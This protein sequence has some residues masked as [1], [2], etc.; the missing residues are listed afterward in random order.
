MI[1]PSLRKLLAA[2]ARSLDERRAARAEASREAPSAER[3]SEILDF[4]ARV[5]AGGDED[6]LGR[7]LGWDG[8]TPEEAVEAAAWEEAA[9]APWTEFLWEALSRPRGER[10][11]KEPPEFGAFRVVPAFATAWIPFV[12]AARERA[13]RAESVDAELFAPAA[14]RALE[15]GLLGELARL[16]QGVFPERLG[17]RS[18][19]DAQDASPSERLEEIFLSFPVLARLV[20][21]LATDWV[22]STCELRSRLR[23]DRAA[24][25]EAFGAAGEVTAVRSA[26]SDRHRGGRRVAILTFRSGARVVYK[27]RAVGLEAEWN[28]FLEWLRASGARDAPPALRFVAREGY[29]WSEFAA[30]APLADE[31]AVAAYF[32]RAGGLLAVAWLLGARDFHMDN[33]V[34]TGAGPVVVDAEAVLQ[35][36]AAP[37]SGRGPRGAFDAANARLDASFVPTGLLTLEQ[38]DAEGRLSDVGGL[39]GRGEGGANLPTCGG[40]RLRPEDRPAAVFQGFKSMYRHLLARRAELVAEDGPLSRFGGHR[41]RVVYRPSEAYARLLGALAGPRYLRD[42]WVRSVGIDSLNRPFAALPSSPALWPLVADERAALERMD[43]PYFDLGTTEAEPVSDSGLRVAGHFARSGIEALRVRLAKMGEGDLAAQE[44]LLAAFLSRGVSSRAPAVDAGAGPVSGRC[45]FVPRE[46]LVAEAVRLAD[47]ILGDAVVGE[48]GALAWIDSAAVRGAD[49]PERGS[50]Y[51]LYDGGAGILLFFAAAAATTGF[52]RFRD[53]ARRVAIP[54]R[55][56]LDDSRLPVLLAREGLGVLSGTGSLVY[57]LAVAAGLLG[58]EWPF[59]VAERAAG[60]ITRDRIAADVAYDVEG[61]AAGAILGLLALHAATEDAAALRTAV[62]C[63]EHLVARRE[64]LGE[65]AWGWPSRGGL[66]LGG[67]AH[68]TSGIAL[69]FARLAAAASRDDFL[70]AARAARRHEAALF[71]AATGN[72]PA[73]VGDGATVRRVDMKAWCHGAPGIALSM[74][75]ARG[76]G[77]ASLDRALGVALETTRRAGLL[78]LDH[79]CCGNAGLVEALAAAGDTLG[80]PDLVSGAEARLGAMLG[81]SR[82]LGGF[83]LRGTEEENAGVLPGFFRGQAGIGYTLL[84]RARPGLLPNVLAFETGA[85]SRTAREES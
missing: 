29:G 85:A 75:Q 61:G 51:Y 1:D 38:S 7:R 27:P 47:G 59:A 5:F 55:T 68:G 41:L 49:R 81:R 9:D 79:A 31:E 19:T 71:D 15:G 32:R 35:P 3:G 14:L 43:I 78:S 17:P 50:S 64:D 62:A 48:D 60:A 57:A 58:E 24:L 28:G 45:P 65:G 46:E 18:E 37:V 53:A 67:M 8:W 23:A 33:V 10:T 80:R 66:R 34:A 74:L 16:G 83:R 82:L 4:W 12:R 30:P 69:A 54:I 11:E 73:L 26:V 72:W 77:D 76:P 20:S 13:R 21:T 56:V 52:E 2:R 39:N 63:A 44:R 40:V 6:A 36:D 25:A 42:G 84:R 22:A 70:D